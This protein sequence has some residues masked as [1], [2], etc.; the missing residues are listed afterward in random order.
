LDVV[1]EPDF[2]LYPK[3]MAAAAAAAAA[4]SSQ[5]REALTSTTAAPTPAATEAS[6]APKSDQPSAALTALL[7]GLT[8]EQLPEVKQRYQSVSAALKG[9]EQQLLE[10]YYSEGQEGE[11]QEDVFGGEGVEQLEGKVRAKAAEVRMQLMQHLLVLDEEFQA[12]KDYQVSRGGWSYVLE[13][14]TLL[15]DPFKVQLWLYLS[16]TLA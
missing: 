10:W 3:A 7:S 11:E 14:A 6:A 15:W 9:G 13:A 16:Q 12:P 1:F 2:N 8:R 5:S 4:R